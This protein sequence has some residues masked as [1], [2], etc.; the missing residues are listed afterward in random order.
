MPALVVAS[1]PLSYSPTEADA[2][3]CVAI[4]GPEDGGGQTASS[5]FHVDKYP[6]LQKKLSMNFF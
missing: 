3:V 1:P 2:M 4:G 6:T 5:K